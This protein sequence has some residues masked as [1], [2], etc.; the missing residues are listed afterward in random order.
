M[1]LVVALAANNDEIPFHVRSAIFMMF[2]V[3]QFEDSRVGGGPTLMLPSANAAGVAVTFIHSPLNG[4]GNPAVVGFRN[5]FVGLQGVL[6]HVQVG[7]PRKPRGDGVALFGAKLGGCVK[8]E[9]V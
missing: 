7:A 8:M 4:L 3:V 2:K 6:S 5:A 1:H 9:T